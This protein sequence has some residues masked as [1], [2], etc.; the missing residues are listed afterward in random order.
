M[1]ATNEKVKHALGPMDVCEP[2]DYGD[3]GGDCVVVC[4]DDRRIAVFLGSGMEATAN[5]NLFAA[6]PELLEALKMLRREWGAFG[7]ISGES[8][9]Q[10]DNVIAKAEGVA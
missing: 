1:T 8:C 3:Y 5:A 9:I 7:K 6:A 2:G 10:A 4:G